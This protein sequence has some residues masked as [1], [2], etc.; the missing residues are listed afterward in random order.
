MH[1]HVSENTD[2][3]NSGDINGGQGELK[4]RYWSPLQR[5]KNSGTQI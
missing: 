3:S 4:S 2:P 5:M 1:M